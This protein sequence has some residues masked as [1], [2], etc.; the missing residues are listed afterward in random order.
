MYIYVSVVLSCLISHRLGGRADIRQRPYLIIDARRVESRPHVALAVRACPGHGTASR[1]VQVRA[2]IL[3]EVRSVGI[4]R[5]LPG[6]D[7]VALSRLGIVEHNGRSPFLHHTMGVLLSPHCL[8]QE[9][10]LH[11][12]IERCV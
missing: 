6:V 1:D 9:R 7:S 3:A 5:A 11:L 2:S 10:G 12:A 8:M 4:G